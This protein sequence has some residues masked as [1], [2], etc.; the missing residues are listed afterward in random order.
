[1]SS[2]AYRAGELRLFRVGLFGRSHNS[3]RSAAFACEPLFATIFQ[4]AVT[5]PR[6]LAGLG[7]EHHQLGNIDRE[8]FVQP[9]ALGVALARFDVLVDLVDAFYD[10]LV[11]GVVNRDNFASLAGIFAAQYL[12]CVANVNLHLLLSEI[13]I[14]NDPGSGPI[15]QVKAEKGLFF[16]ASPDLARVWNLILSRPAGRVP[17]PG[18]AVLQRPPGP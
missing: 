12:D 2:R 8:F 10:C 13:R 6:G 18:R 5:N 7:A 11:I 1:M 15:C 17:P 9:T 3:H 4:V 14:K 16:R